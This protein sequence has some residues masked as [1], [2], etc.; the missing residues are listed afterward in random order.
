MFERALS[1]SCRDEAIGLLNRPQ[2]RGGP[3]HDDGWVFDA[4]AV[5][6]TQAGLATFVATQAERA[7][8]SAP[9]P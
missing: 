1:A 5:L 2:A 6:L 3:Q 4:L 9:V 7:G 8:R